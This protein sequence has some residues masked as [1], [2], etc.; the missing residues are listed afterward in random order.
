MST[1]GRSQRRPCGS[2]WHWRQTDGWHYTPPG[3][4]RRV[5]LVDEDGKQIRGKDNRQAAE[6]ALA[7]VKVAGRWRPTAEPP[8]AVVLVVEPFANQV[9]VDPLGR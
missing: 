1:N 5:P 3:T 2:A 8:H 4:K 9:L 6:L 7:R